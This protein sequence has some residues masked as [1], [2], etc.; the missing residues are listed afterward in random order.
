MIFLKK[1]HSVGLVIFKKLEALFYNSMIKRFF[2]KHKVIILFLIFA[3]L[4]RLPWLYTTVHK[5]EGQIGYVAWRWLSGENLYTELNDNKPLLLYVIYSLP[6]LLFGNTVIPIRIL[7]DLFFLVSIIFFFKLVE[8]I[9]SKKTALFSALFYTVFMSVPVFE[10]YFALSEPLLMPFL[11]ISVYSLE[12]YFSTRKCYLLFMASLFASISILIKHQAV[13]IFLFMASTFFIYKEKNKVRKILSIISIPAAITVFLLIFYNKTLFYFLKIN[14]STF[15][16]SIGVAA[17]YRHYSFNLIIILEGSLLFLFSILGLVKVFQSKKNKQDLFFLSWLI[18]ALLFSLIPPAYGRYYIFL[19]PPLAVFSGISMGYFIK[20]YKNKKILLLLALVFL[21]ATCALVTKQF[22]NSKLD[23][24]HFKY[25]WAYLDSYEQQ[26][27]LADYVKS[28]TSPKDEIF[29]FGWEPSVY[30][31]SER[32]P[33]KSLGFSF[34]EALFDWSYLGRVLVNQDDLK[35]VIIL[36]DYPTLFL[37]DDFFFNN[38][39]IY[40][41]DVYEINAYTDRCYLALTFK[42]RDDTLCD[43]ISTP[44]YKHMCYAVL[45]KNLDKCYKINFLPGRDECLFFVASEK[46]DI[47]ICNLIRDVDLLTFCTSRLRNE[48]N[49]TA[50]ANFFTAPARCVRYYAIFKKD[51]KECDNLSSTDDMLICKAL[52]SSD[53]AYCEGIHDGSVRSYCIAYTTSDASY[54]LQKG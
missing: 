3:L 26:K 16:S 47:K 14:W 36:G 2:S 40:G 46:Q 37:N 33:P 45:N 54:C 9:F 8:N 21:I 4:I 52:I 27:G 53:E 24:E 7:N 19:I 51:T 18:F 23:T 1:A 25:G 13:F 48:F 31:M 30:W 43:L 44:V 15:Q 41:A 17:G 28:T 32:M 34:R 38:K 50:C 10:G 39:R 49:H 29:V 35:Q 12:R 6:I 42:D 22:P 5:D 20:D 11:I